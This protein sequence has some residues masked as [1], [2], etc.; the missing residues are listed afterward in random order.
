MEQR[1]SEW[2]NMRLGKF[3][4]SR[5]HE[6]MGSKP[7]TLTAEKYILS[8]VAEQVIREAQ[9]I[10][11]TFAMQHGIDTEPLAISHYERVM[12]VT[13]ESYGFRMCETITD[14][15]CSP[16]GIVKGENKG[17]E[18]KCPFD[19]GTHIKYI[20]YNDQKDLK[21]FSKEYYWQVLMNMWVFDLKEWDFVSYHPDFKGKLRMSILPVYWD[22]K[23][24]NL[25]QERVALAVT[26]KNEMVKQ[27]NNL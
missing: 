20:L 9:E 24:I 22:D 8:R 4:A 11:T 15:G 2:H 6:L 1:S 3:T 25:L 14:A 10:P 17:I 26:K 18:V 16:D 27:L 12:G 7:D 13:V 23:D 19:K 5:I 21:K